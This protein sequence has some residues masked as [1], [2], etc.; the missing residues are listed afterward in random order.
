MSQELVGRGDA[1]DLEDDEMDDDSELTDAEARPGQEA[2]AD[3]RSRRR[4]C[5]RRV[6]LEPDTDQLEL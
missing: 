2:A 5:W 1:S 3:P 4:N 6:L